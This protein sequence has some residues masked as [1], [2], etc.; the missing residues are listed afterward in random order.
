MPKV[1][2][3]FVPWPTI[4]EVKAQRAELFSGH[5]ERSRARSPPPPPQQSSSS[6]SQQHQ[7]RQR[8]QSRAR[9]P[10]KMVR[11]VHSVR[12]FSNSKEK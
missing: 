4:E 3:E 11:S 8:S 2:S 9:S 5:R 6:F 7:N 12:F 10:P 1:A